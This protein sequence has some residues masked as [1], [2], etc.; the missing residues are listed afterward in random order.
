MRQVPFLEV[1]MNTTMKMYEVHDE[2][3][4]FLVLASSDREAIRKLIELGKIAEDEAEYFTA[5]EIPDGA[6]LDTDGPIGVRL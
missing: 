6:R 3:N 2:D 4:A 5:S 1:D